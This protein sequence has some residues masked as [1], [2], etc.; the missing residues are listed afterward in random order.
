MPEDGGPA[1]FRQHSIEVL[2]LALD[3]VG[4]DV[5]ALAT[6]TT[7]VIE[8]AEVWRQSFSQAPV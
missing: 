5:T 3:G 7:V 2:D 1:G 6:P 8:D 4:L